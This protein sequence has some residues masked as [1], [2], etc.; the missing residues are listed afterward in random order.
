MSREHA[1]MQILDAAA[2]IQRN[3][4]IILEAKAIETEKARNWLVNHLSDHA[5]KTHKEQID[6]PLTIHDQL[7]DTIDGLTKLENGMSRYLKV[8]LGRDGE[9]SGMGGF[10]EDS[11][12]GGG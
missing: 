5:F 3:I 1:Y 8:V 12:D 4:A 6:Q 2:K 11:G 7:L 10:G 9:D